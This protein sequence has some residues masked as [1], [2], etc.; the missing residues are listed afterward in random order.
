MAAMLVRL[1]SALEGAKNNR[2]PLLERLEKD[3]LVDVLRWANAA[4]ALTAR[5]KGV[6]PALPNA[7]EVKE[8][9]GA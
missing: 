2:R 8:L 4:G 3:V 7:A 5:R 9:I 1:L 6:M